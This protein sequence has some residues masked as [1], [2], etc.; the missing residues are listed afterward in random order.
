MLS[1]CH[2]LT[3]I[4]LSVNIMSAVM[5]CH[6]GVVQYPECHFNDC[7][8]GECKGANTNICKIKCKVKFLTLGVSHR[9]ISQL[10]KG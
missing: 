7:V 9:H 4:M 5:M 6:Y 3:V 2:M 1:E 8:Y 10:Q